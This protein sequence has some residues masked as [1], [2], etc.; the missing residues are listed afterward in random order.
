MMHIDFLVQ[1]L[2][3]QGALAPV[4]IEGSKDSIRQLLDELAAAP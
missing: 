3:G 4:F 1:A 2:H